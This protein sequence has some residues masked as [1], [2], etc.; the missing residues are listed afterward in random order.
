M[1]AQDIKDAFAR[2]GLDAH[3]YGMFCYDEWEAIEEIVEDGVVIQ[4]S[5]PAGS[6]YGI[7]YDELLAFI[8]AAI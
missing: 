7:R 1:I 6:R 8:I 5:S 3:S 4:A 2:H